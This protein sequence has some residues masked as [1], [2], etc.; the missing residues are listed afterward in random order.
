MKWRDPLL[1]ASAIFGLW[2]AYAVSLAIQGSFHVLYPNISASDWTQTLRMHLSSR[3]I[4]VLFAP[5]IVLLT[6]RFPI[7][8]SDWKR[9]AAI[10]A[11]TFLLFS[12][13]TAAL[14]KLLS[15]VLGTPPPSSPPCRATQLRR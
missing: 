13:A 4:W 1:L 2:A 9:H 14:A 5:A 12:T 11:A 3:W 6:R 8:G 7:A 10:H 15:P